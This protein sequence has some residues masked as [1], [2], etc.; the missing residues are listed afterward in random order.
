MESTAQKAPKI[1]TFKWDTLAIL[2]DDKSGKP[3]IGVAG[4]VAG[5]VG[6]MLIVAGGANFPENPPWTGGKKKYH[7]K[8]YILK[9]KEKNHYHWVEDFSAKLNYPIAY[10]ANVPYKKGFIS[11]G[12]E[13][14]NGLLKSVIYFQWLNENLNMTL[15]PELPI[16][17]TSC[18]AVCIKDRLYVVGGNSGK[19]SLKTAF[20][21]DLSK[22]DKKWTAI[23]DM[24]FALENAVAAVCHDGESQKLFLLGG[25]YKLPDDKTTTFSD[26]VLKYNPKSN[27]WSTFDFKNENGEKLK[28]AAGTG[29]AISKSKIAI[30]GG[31]KGIIFNKIESFN[32]KLSQPDLEDREKVNN[33]KIALLTSHEG[34][35]SD[36]Y[37]FDVNKNIWQKSGSIPGLAQVTTS[38]FYWGKSIIIPS[39]EIKPGIRTSMI[40]SIKIR[41]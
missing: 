17:L 5:I 10:P 27:K 21:M 28:L 30:F 26:K 31:D 24:P 4:P 14:D 29:V 7:D 37:I 19:T 38:A 23:A 22:T 12:G 9:K 6:D 25:R 1:L 2:P 32:N 20:V 8:I 41:N 40:R 35:N 13:N 3:N 15:L 39:G 18:S 16:G 33:E 34:F 11:V 36:M